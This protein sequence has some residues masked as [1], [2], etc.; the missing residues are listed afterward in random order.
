LFYTI[1]D[2]LIY[3]LTF[4]LTGIGT[5]NDLHISFI[6]QS[7]MFMQKRFLNEFHFFVKAAIVSK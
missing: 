2:L 5:D 3:L 6:I 7:E 4:L 1:K